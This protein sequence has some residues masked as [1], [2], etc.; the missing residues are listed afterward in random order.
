[1]PVRILNPASEEEFSRYFELRWAL[2]RKPWGQPRGSERDE[3]EARS[4]HVMA[5]TESGEPIAVARLHFNST[6]EAQIRFMAVS[7]SQ[8]GRGIGKAML[9]SLENHAR[10]RG[11]S[12]VILHAR[13]PSVGF[14][15]RAGYE[16]LGSSHTLWGVIPHVLM[17]KLLA[18]R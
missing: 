9:E 17:R 18:H 2:L 1:M 13:D 10:Q 5:C 6:D 12:R 7:G 14:Y 15:A 16:S 4:Y 11:V 8:Q 3:H